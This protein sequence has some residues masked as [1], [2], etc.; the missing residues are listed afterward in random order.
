[1]TNIELANKL[2]DIAANYKTTYVSGC[3]GA[4]LNETNKARWAKEYPKN[5]NR[6]GFKAA[7]GNTFGFDCCNLIKAVIWGWNGDKYAPYGGAKYQSNG[8]PDINESGML[9]KCTRVST[10][11]SKVE[12]GE[13]L[14]MSGHCGVYIGGGLAVE[15]TPAWSGDV[16]ITSAGC[17]IPGYHRRSWIKH[18]YMPWIT[19]EEQK[20]AEKQYY[21]VRK[22][23]EDAASQLGAYE[24][25]DNAIKACKDGY[26]VFDAN[27]IEVYPAQEKA[28]GLTLPTL[29]AGSKG[30]SVKAMQAL[31]LLNGCGMGVYGADG[32]F[33]PATDKA[34][35]QYQAAHGLDADGIV[36]QRTW[37]KLLGIK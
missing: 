8:L 27:G 36:E 10:N 6:E 35:R 28:A 21:R 7:D 37:S 19:Y 17:D 12:I 18:G 34:V 15:C 2:R 11:F 23:W 16:Q 25:L 31:L 29:Q 32:D 5:A 9:E 14:W 20:P 22:S 13:F 1:M 4:P 33:G 26:A 3:F 30:E 24:I